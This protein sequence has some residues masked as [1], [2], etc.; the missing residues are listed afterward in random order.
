MNQTLIKLQNQA[1]LEVEIR[2]MQYEW[3]KRK[4]V[5]LKQDEMV[6]KVLKHLGLWNMEEE[7]FYASTKIHHQ[8]L[9]VINYC[10]GFV[11]FHLRYGPKMK[12]MFVMIDGKPYLDFYKGLDSIPVEYVGSGELAYELRAPYDKKFFE[13]LINN[14]CDIMEF[15]SDYVFMLNGKYYCTTKMLRLFKDQPFTNYGSEGKRN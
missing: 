15:G 4:E 6:Q 2:K 9:E 13:K 14:E 12:E 10:L 8:V 3:W 1:E 5:V 7:A 11:N